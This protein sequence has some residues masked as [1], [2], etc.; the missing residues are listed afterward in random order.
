MPPSLDAVQQLLDALGVEKHTTGSDTWGLYVP[1]ISDAGIAQLHATALPAARLLAPIFGDL[2]TLPLAITAH[3]K[4]Q[5][6]DAC[7]ATMTWLAQDLAQGQITCQVVIGQACELLC[8]L[9]DVV[10]ATYVVA[11]P[12]ADMG[13][14]ASSS[15]S[16]SSAYQGRRAA[17]FTQ[18]RCAG[19]DI[20]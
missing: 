15:S 2:P 19:E 4:E 8:A 3:Q 7:W 10:Y 16:I 13:R 6:T 9:S 5:L 14:A 1:D 20:Q 18:R 12:L 17:D 11:P